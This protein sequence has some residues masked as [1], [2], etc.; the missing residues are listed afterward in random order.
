MTSQPTADQ[1]YPV[2]VRITRYAVCAYPGD[3]INR[4]HFVVTVEDRGGGRW[5][6]CQYGMCLNTSGGWDYE[7]IPSERRDDWLA[8][9]RYDLDTALRLAQQAAP[10]ITVNGSTIADVLAHVAH[11]NARTARKDA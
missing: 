5:A 4:G 6:V 9:H 2:E 7:P 10:K 8:T 11:V 1:Q 3:D